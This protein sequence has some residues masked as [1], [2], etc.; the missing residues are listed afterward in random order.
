MADG[1]VLISWK[2]K[3]MD[4]RAGP[5]RL[6][7]RATESRLLEVK[8][9]QLAPMA[10]FLNR[11]VAQAQIVRFA[12]IVLKKS[13]CWL[14][15][16]AKGSAAPGSVAAQTGIGAAAGISLASFRRF[17]AVAASRNSS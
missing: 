13:A 9:D 6:Q 8:I 16:C 12:P 7:G 2:G 10:P 17:W 15:A 1:V 3:Q 14:L 5:Y 4:A 11:K